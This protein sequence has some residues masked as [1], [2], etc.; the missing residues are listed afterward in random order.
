[1]HVAVYLTT[2]LIL[3]VSADPALPV[4]EPGDIRIEYHPH[5]KRNPKTMGR[6]EFKLAVNNAH[7]MEPPIKEPWL[8]FRSR[9]D[10]DFAEIAH[11]AAMN[12][13]QIDD[14]IK[15]FHRCQQVP[16]KFTLKNYQDLKCSWDASS[17]L[18][19]DVSIYPF[20]SLY[21][22]LILR[23]MEFERD[24][25]SLKFKTTEHEF[26]TFSCPIWGWVLDHLMNSELVR[27]FEWD[28]QNVCRY[29]G[30]EFTRIHTEP[31]TGDRWWEVQSSLPHD[32]KMVSLEIY[33]D[34]SVLSSFG[35]AKGHPVMARILNLPTK[36]RNGEGVGGAQVV[37]WLP[38]VSREHWL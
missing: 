25:L 35:T 26:E 24:E 6:E 5:S 17:K 3:R 4:S 11:N 2:N 34:K 30:S 38:V 9:E 23:P 33:S 16:G 36:V 13:S 19:T 27:Q 14:L 21:C 10:F 7:S 1:M 15:L 12:Q 20:D 18:L 31:W 28:A 29:N 8:P 22:L 32:A 37:G